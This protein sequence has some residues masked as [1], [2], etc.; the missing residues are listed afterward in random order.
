M[1][2]IGVSRRPSPAGLLALIASHGCLFSC[3]ARE[4]MMEDEA[5]PSE[6][7]FE[8]LDS[9]IWNGDPVPGKAGLVRFSWIDQD[10]E[11][12]GGC[13]GTMIGPRL[14]LTAAH[15]VLES[16]SE[17]WAS[18]WYYRPGS[19]DIDGE[20]LGT[21]EAKIAVRDGYTGPIAT[22]DQSETDNWHDIALVRLTDP[23]TSRW[24]STTYQDY[25]RVHH[26]GSLPRWFYTYGTGPQWMNGEGNKELRR[27]HFEVATPHDLYLD[28]N[29]GDEGVC[30]GDSGGPSMITGTQ[31][32]LEPAIIAGVSSSGY[33]GSDEMCAEGGDNWQMTL[34]SGTN[35]NFLRSAAPE[36]EIIDRPSY[37][38]YLRCF[39]LPFISDVYDGD[40]FEKPEAAAI[41]VAAL[42]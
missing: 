12:S 6:V 11:V 33:L 14:I 42:L 15:C 18:V 27:G 31:G 22:E 26:A 28:L 37:Y 38:D 23:T 20:H 3:S 32:E 8:T 35:G 5:L 25:V 24:P 2:E 21:L 13:A 4:A 1:I 30:A 9:P 7:S 17:G 10:G 29:T 34:V 40:G 36:C 41:A 19:A 39:K 16:G